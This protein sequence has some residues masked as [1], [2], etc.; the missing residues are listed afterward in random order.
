MLQSQAASESSSWITCT[1]V[2]WAY[3]ASSCADHRPNLSRACL[4]RGCQRSRSSGSHRNSAAAPAPLNPAKVASCLPGY[5]KRVPWRNQIR[6]ALKSK[7]RSRL[8][9]WLSKNVKF[10][11][12]FLRICRSSSDQIFHARVDTAM[13]P[14]NCY[15]LEVFH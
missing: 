1:S 3:F 11:S 4:A 12:Y 2:R 13:S 9:T 6:E 7:H 15:P 5:K 10:L 14:P 8:Q